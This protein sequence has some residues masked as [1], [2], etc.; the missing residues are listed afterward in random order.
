MSKKY[1]QGGFNYEHSIMYICTKYYNNKYNGE[2]ILGRKR[3]VKINDIIFTYYKQDWRLH[4]NNGRLAFPQN[5]VQCANCIRVVKF[6]IYL[7][8]NDGR[9]VCYLDAN[10]EYY[11]Y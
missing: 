10:E 4:N 6:G 2:I 8:G 3:Y 11:L 9:A 5:S 1:V 7:L